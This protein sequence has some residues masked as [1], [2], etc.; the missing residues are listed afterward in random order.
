MNAKEIAD[1]T[2]GLFGW[3]DGSVGGWRTYTYDERLHLAE[4]GL[5]CVPE[6]GMI[7]EIGSYT[8]LSTGV[9]LQVARERKAKF[10][11]VDM[12]MWASG[13]EKGAEEVEAHL[14]S[15]LCQFPDV[16]WRFY[17]TSSEI[18]H[19][20][21]TTKPSTGGVTCPEWI[22]HNINLL[23]IDG[24]HL[25]AAADCE[26]WVP[27]VVGTGVVAF[28]DANPNPAAPIGCMV[29]ADANKYTGNWTTLWHSLNENCLLIRRKP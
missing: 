13:Y 12:F 28:H 4:A 22:D 8:G 19:Y 25:A 24:N 9:L 5:D 27:H 7:V 6:G 3:I 11:S 20:V 16:W 23:H 10:A 17:Y 14:R 1:W 15:V 29:V 2:E 18:A 21:M 26:I